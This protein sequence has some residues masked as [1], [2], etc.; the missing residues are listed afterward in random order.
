[1][2]VDV[3]V[4]DDDPALSG[5]VPR[6]SHPGGNITGFTLM[7]QELNAKRLEL[8]RTTFPD[9]TAVAVLIDPSKPAWT[10]SFQ[11]I[12]EAARALGL[13]IA[14]VEAGSADALLVLRPAASSGASAVLVAPGAMFWN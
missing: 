10:R 11:P 9:I 13:P 14:R 6:L 3:I 12:E 7:I 4:T 2:P 5:L 1:M 8:L